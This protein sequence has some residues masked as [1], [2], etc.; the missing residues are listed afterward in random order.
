MHYIK[1]TLKSYLCFFIMFSFITIIYT[2][3]IYFL[4]PDINQSTLQIISL[5]ISIFIFFIFGI[6]VGLF[7]QKKGLICG[8]L[9]TLILFG[10]VILIN[11]I[12]HHFNLNLIIKAILATI[13]AALGGLI[14]VNFKK[15]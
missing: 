5:F 10:I 13:S 1:N 2:L 6:I 11:L 15:R 4:H 12:C 7:N 8:A 14:S 9:S 3:I